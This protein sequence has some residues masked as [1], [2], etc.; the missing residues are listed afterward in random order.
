MIAYF[1]ENWLNIQEQWSKFHITKHLIFGNETNNRLESTNQ[2]L[3]AVITKYASMPTFFHLLMSCVSS[4]HIEKDIITAEQLMRKPMATFNYAVYDKEYLKLMTNFAFRRYVQERMN[5]ARVQFVH[6]DNIMGVS[7]RLRQR[8]ITDAKSCE[9]IVF[10]TMSIPCRH[11]LSFRERNAIDLFDPAL[12]NVRWLKQKLQTI[13]QIDYVL[14]SQP[15]IEI[16]ESTS[17]PRTTRKRKTPA[18]KF[19]MVQNKCNELCQ[20]MAELPETQFGEQ[21]SQLCK[22]VENVRAHTNAEGISPLCYR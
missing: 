8:I 15:N 19:R 4:M 9:C 22:F 18:Q 3:K 5:A 14:D 20:L 6:I 7:G 21:Y 10:T 17:Q 16:V 2:K 12:I 11:I 13:S 1:N